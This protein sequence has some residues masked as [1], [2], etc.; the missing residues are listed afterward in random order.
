MPS[1]SPWISTCCTCSTLSCPSLWGDKANNE[2]DKANNEGDKA[3]NKGDKAI[4]EED[5]QSHLERAVGC[6]RLNEIEGR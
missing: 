1:W 2:G 5:I 6:M 4:N 3:N